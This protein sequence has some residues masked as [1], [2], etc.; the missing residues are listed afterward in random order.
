M[1]TMKFGMGQSV[2]RSE[3]ARFITGNGHYATDYAPDGAL[4]AYFVRSPHA[5]ATFTIRNLET[6]RKMKGVKAVWT[7]EDVADL[8]IVPCQALIPSSDGS[9]TRQ[10][11][12]AVL[13]KG[14]TRHVGDCVAFIVATTLAQAKDAAEALEIDYKELPVVVGI[15]AAMKKGAPLVWPALGTNVVMDAHLG[16]KDKT[17]KAF[18]KADKVVSIRLVNNRLIAN[19]M[20]PRVCTAEYDSAGKSWKLTLGS[21]GVH[22]LRDTLAKIMH[23]KPDRIR[24]ITPDV[25]GGFGNKSFMYREYPLLAKAAKSLRKP[26]SWTQERAEHFLTCVHGRDNIVTGEM[27][28]SKSGKFL[29]MRVDLLADLGAYLSQYGPYIPF[30]GGTMTTGLYDIPAA[31]FRVRGVYTHTVPVDAYRGAGRPEAAYLIERLVDKIAFETGKTPDKVR[32]MNFIRPNQ[33]PYKT[34]VGRTYDSGEFDAH[35]RK[36][37]EVAGWETF[38]SRNAAAKRK[39]LIRGIGMASYV[40][41]CAFGAPEPAYVSLDKEGIVTIKIGTQSTGQGHETAYAQ[42]ASQYLDLPLSQIRVL[43]GDTTQTPTGGGTGGSRSIPVGGAAVDIAARALAEN[44]KAIAADELEANV[45]DLEIVGGR[46][47]VAG[48][49]KS[50][51]LA[52]IAR[53]KK[54]TVELLNTTGSFTQPEATYPNGTHIC[55]VE[56]DPETGIVRIGNYVVVDDFG[57][58]LNPLLLAGQVHGGIAQGI[59][60]ALIERTVYDAEGQL[61]TGT[62]ND[63]A[64]PRAD[65]LPTFDFQTRNVPCVTNHLGLKGAG[66]AG[67]IG[68]TPAVANAVV[69]ALHRAYGITHIDIPATAQAIHAAIAARR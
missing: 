43:Q 56:I 37:M 53:S 5:H 51:S 34:Q 64:M 50:R 66:E 18:A 41:A 61:V 42:L 62:F 15:E 45:A 32:A 10:T 39:G 19:Y 54:A 63:Y 8:G 17:D 24:V 6:V 52:E 2:R 55:E 58:T 59:G 69:D 35:M 40:E 3:D 23:V 9:G 4:S 33:L 46:V 60:Q 31:Y 44:I 67:S 30:L 21:Q 22:G 13:C 38:K 16:D 47:T 27:A 25:G 65:D 49:D 20:E 68:S 14:E 7:H 57:V 11:E 28:L 26:V 12:Y 29:A 1:K 36:A 48:T